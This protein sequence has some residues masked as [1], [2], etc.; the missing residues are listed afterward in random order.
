[1]GPTRRDGTP[2]KPLDAVGKRLYQS[3]VGSLLYAACLTRMDL[4]HATAK[5]THFSAVPAEHHLL[6]AKHVLRYWAGTRTLGLTFR[7]SNRKINLNP[8]VYPDASWISEINSGRSHSGVITLLN[9]SPIHWWSKQ[10]SMIA[11]SSTE[12]EYI[13]MGEAAK[14][15][16]WLREWLIAVLGV[17]VPIRVI[18]DNQAAIMIATNNVDSARTRHYSARHHYV[19]ELI[20]SNQLKLEWINTHDQAAD[21][22]TKQLTEDKLKVWRDRFLSHVTL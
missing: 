14:D 11:L 22:L 6:A 12:A 20:Q 19:R 21:M 7:R 15:A 9:D 2:V 13:A 3:M 8:T 4:T 18:C 5:L 17:T 10:Q 16:V 1:L